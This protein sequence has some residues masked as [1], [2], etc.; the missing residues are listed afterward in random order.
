[1]PLNTKIII[2]TLV[3]T[4]AIAS[5]IDSGS[6]DT[7]MR[8]TLILATSCSEG[9]VMCSDTRLIQGYKKPVNYDYV[10]KLRPIGSQGMYAISGI[11]FILDESDTNTSI[12]KQRR[13]FDVNKIVDNFFREHYPKDIDKNILQLKKTLTNETAQFFSSRPDI[14]DILI[15]NHAVNNTEKA[16]FQILIYVINEH[17]LISGYKL[18]GFLIDGS[19]SRSFKVKVDQFTKEFFTIADLSY[20]GRIEV[21]DKIFKGNDPIFNDILSDPDINLFSSQLKS[22]KSTKGISVKQVTTLLEKLIKITNEKLPLLGLEV[23]VGPYC[24]CAVLNPKRGFK[25][26]KKESS[27]K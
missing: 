11:P 26:I 1:M 21:I 16:L 14:A 2:I 27:G 23:S 10:Q 9:V 4:T 18:S 22:K 15:E 6:K 19:E 8:G 25:W 7:S 17:K 12:M 13:L 5:S 20:N 24:D 3:L